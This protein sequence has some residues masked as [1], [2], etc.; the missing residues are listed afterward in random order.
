[1]RPRLPYCV[2]VPCLSAALAFASPAKAT[3]GATG[4]ITSLAIL[5]TTYGQVIITNPVGTST[6]TSPAGQYTFDISTNK[7]K[8]FLSLLE[9]AQLAGK[10]VGVGGDGTCVTVQAGLTIENLSILTVF[11]N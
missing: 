10:T 3:T 7:G 11:T 8:A 9:G 6:C 2:F 5:G 4:Q 1:M